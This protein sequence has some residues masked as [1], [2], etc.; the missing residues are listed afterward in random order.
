MVKDRTV[1]LNCWCMELFYPLP[2]SGSFPD[3]IFIWFSILD[4]CHSNSTGTLWFKRLTVFPT[5]LRYLVSPQDP[6]RSLHWG[7]IG[8]YHS[9]QDGDTVKFH[10]CWWLLVDLGVSRSCVLPSEILLGVITSRSK[11]QFFC[12][13]NCH[14][15]TNVVRCWFSFYT[16]DKGN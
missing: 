13:W 1:S 15:T 9:L 6:G 12:Y 8:E 4:L 5:F 3:T 14:F 16:S 10:P 11:P 2:S 7:Q